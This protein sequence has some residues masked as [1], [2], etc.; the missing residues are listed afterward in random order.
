MPD[1][2]D[3]VCPC[4]KYRKKCTAKELL[5]FHLK[6]T[7]HSCDDTVIVAERDKPVFDEK[8][9][10]IENGSFLIQDLGLM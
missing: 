3:Y 4:Y 8:D 10:G 2:E 5:K 7:D 9:M 6:A 1:D